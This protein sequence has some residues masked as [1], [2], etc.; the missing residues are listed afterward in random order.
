MVH[1]HHIDVLSIAIIALLSALPPFLPSPAP[2]PSPCLTPAPDASGAEDA[3][4]AI[5]SVEC[6][7]WA[8]CPIGGLEDFDREDP[9]SMCA[10]TRLRLETVRMEE[11]V[12]RSRGLGTRK[13]GHRDKN[14]VHTKQLL[15]IMRTIFFIIPRPKINQ[16]H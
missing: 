14:A 16:H 2:L 10:V 8:G 7:G 3:D 13:K 9:A 12:G 11:P 5:E 6:S 15:G 1:Q 4:A